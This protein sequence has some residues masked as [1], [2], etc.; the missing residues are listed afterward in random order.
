MATA[1]FTN[2]TASGWQ[3]VSFSTPVLIRANTVYVVSYYA[4]NGHYSVNTGYFTSQ[5]ASNG[6]LQGLASGPAGANGLYSYGA[7][8]FP[9]TTYGQSNYWVDVT[10]NTNVTP[11]MSPPTVVS[12]TPTNNTTA[13]TTDSG[14]VIQF[15]EALN[16]ATVNT[17]TVE[18]LNPDSTTIPAGCCGSPGGWCSGCPLV[19]G[20]QTKVIPATVS[21]NPTN[22]TVTL[23][24]TAPLSTLQTYTVYVK[25]GAQGVTDLAGNPVAT[26]NAASFLTPAQVA[27]TWSAIW[28]PTISPT[29]VDS[30]DTQPIEVGTKFSSSVAGTI[31]G[32][33][34]YKSAGDI[35]THTGSLWSSTGQ[36]LATG[37]FVDESATGWQQLI[38][39]SPV[40]ITAGT[41]Y[42]VSYHTNAGHYSD[43]QN[44]FA[45]PYTSGPL[46]VP[47]SGGVYLYGAGGF[48]TQNYNNSNYWV[49][50]ILRVAPPVDN[51]A[52]TIIGITPAAG[53]T[54]VSVNPSI[55][56]AFSEAIDPTTA[57]S[58]Q[59]RLMDQYN[60]LVPTTVTY[61]AQT[62]TATITPTS[63]LA[64]GSDYTIVV[65]GGA[66]GVRDLAGNPVAATI[67]SSFTTT[68]S[69]VPDTTPPIVI[70]TSP[71]SNATGYTVSGAVTVTFSEPLNAATVN[72]QS[73]NIL[74]NGV[75]R[76]AS[77]AVYNPT[78][79]SLTITPTAPLAYGTSY[80]VYIVGGSTG[81]RDL[82]GNT[83]A[84]NFSSSFTTAAAPPPTSIWST[85]TTP[86]TVDEGSSQALTVGVQF[87]PSTNGYI[88]GVEFYKAS[89][90]TGT[91]TGSLWSSTGT[92]LAT[93]TFTNETASG[94][95]TLTFA[96]PVAVTAGTTYVASYFAPNGHFS[97]N[98]NYFASAF[99]SGS[100]T[101]PVS[102]GVFTYG[103]SMPS[104][105]AAIRTAT[106][107]STCCSVSLI[108][109]RPR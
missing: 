97:V 53:T 80:T 49:Q 59:L 21:Y 106:T 54:G 38:F 78:T 65:A 1:T 45:S 47:V 102:G 20:A 87:T 83:L 79:D 86:T 82:S 63:A 85:T 23:I 31:A 42:V 7:D 19:Q 34:F 92:L 39:T 12:Y 10:I 99:T 22:D 28:S 5:G 81:I 84:S 66:L 71:A 52:P 35:G 109:P 41:T 67:G 107:G 91:H 94:W 58:N 100:L 18:L 57:T 95:Q 74:L 72:A 37:T 46:T 70:D 25:G 69:L 16:P 11:D 36:L 48:P 55:T 3:Q 64:F 15:S 27:S 6:P 40:A 29:T 43:D 33:S 90:N 2:E 51:V 8:A 60:H 13:L 108:R 103:S 98:S 73:A 24:P 32:V 105:R 76:V 9:I 4:P 62:F 30:G 104:R 96:T 17:T 14:I 93:G 77:T 89:T 44:Y 75:T 101:V 50:P 56:V 68:G 88:N 26:D 61:N